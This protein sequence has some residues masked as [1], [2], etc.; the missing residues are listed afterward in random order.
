MPGLLDLARAVWV[1]DVVL[2]V[3]VAVATARHWVL[4]P[5]TA[6]GHLDDP[7][8]AHFYGAPP[9]ALMTVGAGALLVGQ[10]LIGTGSAVVLDAV[11]WT[12]GTALGLV[13]AV[14]VPVRV[15]ATHGARPEEAFGGWLMP[16]VPPMLARTILSVSN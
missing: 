14:A 5:A 2:L 11:L 12:V 13:T 6:R 16:I 4:D 10:P 15:A 7:V 9:M 8:M 1:L 3:A